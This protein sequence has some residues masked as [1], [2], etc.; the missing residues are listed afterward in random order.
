MRFW[1]P[2]LVFAGFAAQ[3]PATQPPPAPS[4]AVA[5]TAPAAPR[6]LADEDRTMILTLLARIETLSTKFDTESKAGKLTVDRA[7]FD[8]IAADVQQIRTILQK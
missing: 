1:L 5:A 6:H 7:T 3:A 8:E 2:V 4:P